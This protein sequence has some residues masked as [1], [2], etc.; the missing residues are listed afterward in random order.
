MRHELK[1]EI[2]RLE[3]F[4]EGFGDSLVKC[5]GASFEEIERLEKELQITFCQDLRDLWQFSNGSDYSD[6]FAVV[7][8]ELTFCGFP[9]IKDAKE[10]WSC[11]LPFDESIVEEW[12]Y[13][14]TNPDSR[15]KPNI[16]VNRFWFPIAEF[17]GF[18]TKVMFDASPTQTGLYGQIIVYQHDPDAIYYVAESFLDFFKKSNDL[19]EV[20]KAYFE[21]LKSI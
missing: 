10:A 17:N 2:D 7:S 15:I 21:E 1:I 8:D 6:W 4:L 11:H 20:N 5:E 16:L 18:S 19:F 3:K 13:P 12:S 14:E 9:N